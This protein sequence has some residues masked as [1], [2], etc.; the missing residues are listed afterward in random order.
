MISSWSLFIQL[1]HSVLT[2]LCTMNLIG[3]LHISRRMEFRA[4]RRIFSNFDPRSYHS[5]AS[6]IFSLFSLISVINIVI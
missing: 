4:A 2:V 5:T 3:L 1:P 6:E